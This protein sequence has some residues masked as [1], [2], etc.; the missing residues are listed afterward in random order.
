MQKEVVLPRC[1]V[2]PINSLIDT[3]LQ[4]RTPPAMRA[5]VLGVLNAGTMAGLPLGTFAFGFVAAWIGLRATLAVMGAIYLMATLS[6][7]VNPALK[8][9]EK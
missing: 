3:V 9:M 1:D 2:M 8:K 5:R 7:L 4:E 6:I